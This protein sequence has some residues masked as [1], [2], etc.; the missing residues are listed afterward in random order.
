MET[1]APRPDLGAAMVGFRWL[2]APGWGA[3]MDLAE[4][5][6][7]VGVPQQAPNR[8]GALPDGHCHL[9]SDMAVLEVP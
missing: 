6:D 8:L 5:S 2:A 1:V 9:R 7:P 4:I 3:A